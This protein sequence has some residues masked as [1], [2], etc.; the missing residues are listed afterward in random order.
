MFNYWSDKE[1]ADAR[2]DRIAAEIEEMRL[3]DAL[4]KNDGLPQRALSAV[5]GALVTLGTRLQ[6]QQNRDSKI[7]AYVPSIE[8]LSH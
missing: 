2:R 1:H 6:E 5:G 4:Q 8:T 7:P 3:V